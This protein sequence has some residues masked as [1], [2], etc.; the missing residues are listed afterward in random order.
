[1][2]LEIGNTKLDIGLFLAPM[3][4]YTDRAMRMVAHEAGA[5]WSV[6][7]MVS[8]KA[9]VFGD[10]KTFNLARIRGDEGNVSLQIFGSEP[11]VMAK[12]ASVLERG[13]TEDGY[14]PPLAIDIN[15]GCPVN[16]VFGNGDGSALMRDP[17]LIYKIVKS[18]S[19]NTA[20]PTTVK[21]RAGID[22][23]SINAVECALAAE[24]GGASLVAVHGRTRSQLYGGRADRNI[25]RDVKKALHIPVIANGDITDGQSA[26]DMLSDTGADGIMIGRAA[27]GNPFVFSQIVSAIR[28]VDYE[29]P[30]LRKRI[31]VA[32][33]QLNL[34]VEDKGEAVAVTEARKQIALYFKGFK[35]S[36]ALRAKINTLTTYKEAERAIL[37]IENEL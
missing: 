5:E 34:A 4:G 2:G 23:S 24:A 32:L 35:G 25:I 27:V 9:V 20:I 10:K 3:A 15:M 6:T 26:L 28:G 13:Y 1:V 7:E 11:D 22:S 17:E 19:E 18:V 36:A 16:K 29:E 33:R 37:E 21:L 12:A 14:V 30:T 8:A 31:S